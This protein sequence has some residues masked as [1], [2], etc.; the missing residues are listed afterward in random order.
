MF[1]GGNKTP[2][3]PANQA[4][5]DM[6]APQNQVQS[7]I[8]FDVGVQDF[9]QRVMMASMQKPV[10]VDFWAPWCGPCKQLGPALEKVISEQG[11]AVLMAKVN[12]DDNQELAA[13]LRIQSIPT[14]YAFFQ[15][16]PVDGFQGALPESQI[17]EFVT[18]LMTLAKSAQPDAID[19]PEVLKNAAQ[20]LSDGDV[21]AAQALYAHILQQDSANVEAYTGMVRTFIAAGQLEQAQAVIE[22][23]PEEIA[24][25]PG[26]AQARSALELASAGPASSLDEL[27]RKIEKNPKDHESRIELARGLFASGQKMAGIEALLETIQIDREWSEQAARKELLKF[28]EALGNSDPLTI[29]GRKK[30]SSILFS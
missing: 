25:K 28:F 29:E 12:L 20:A 6:S 27:A 21:T 19:I 18:K 23:V 5:P 16:Q 17:R 10:I 4:M 2:P 11:G 15:G 9:E 3:P 1:F 13:A 14:V 7:P 26:F 22:N 24:N 8:I 30:L